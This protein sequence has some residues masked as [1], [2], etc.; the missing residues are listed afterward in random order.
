MMKLLA[1]GALGLF[2]IGVAILVRPRPME[3]EMAGGAEPPPP[4]DDPSD[5]RRWNGS[6]KSGATLGKRAAPPASETSQAKVTQPRNEAA[7]A[8][9]A[10]AAENT[11]A[12]LAPRAPSSSRP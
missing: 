9:K 3:P 7:P 10:L 1:A 8:G 11:K 6:S 5:S 4:R 2:A 12:T